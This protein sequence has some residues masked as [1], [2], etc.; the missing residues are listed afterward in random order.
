MAYPTV[1]YGPDGE[2]FNTYAATPINAQRWPFG[3][4]MTLQD[5]RKYRFCSAGG[6]TLTIGDI[7]Q[8]SANVTN[9]QGRTGIAAAVGAR[10]PTLTLGGATT[11][12]L[13]AEGYFMISVTPG[14]GGQGLHNATTADFAQI[15]I[16]ARAAAVNAWSDVRLT[17][18]S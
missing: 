1:L 18:D 3:T 11:Q 17:I 6:S 10:A 12:N 9:D 8:S 15:G 13:Y 16:T 2:Q 7:E 5:G 4:Q 14:A